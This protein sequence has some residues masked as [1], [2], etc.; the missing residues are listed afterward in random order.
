MQPVPDDQL[1]VVAPDD[2][3]FLPTGQSPLQNHEGFLHTTC[4][5]C[6]GPARRETDTM[7]TFVDSSWYFLRFCDPWAT[8]APFDREAAAG[9]MPVGQ[10][11]GGVE[12]AILHLMYAR[13]FTK[14]LADLGVAPPDL[15]EPFSRLFT[16][17]MVR[18][19]GT[20]MSK[21]KGNLVAPE[22]I[23]DREGADALRLAHLF[24]GPPADD[25]DWEGVGIDGCSRFLHRLWR[26]TTDGL[27]I[28]PVDRPESDIDRAV[29][30]STHRLIKKAS[31]DYERWSYNTVV[32]ACM[33]QLNDLYRYVQSDAGP[34]RETLATALDVLLL[35]LAPMA[36]HVTAELW[37]RRHGGEH[38]HEQRW[39]LA[40]PAKLEVE[41]VTMVVQVNGKVRAK[42]EVA[43]D[44][45]VDEA[46]ALALGTEKIAAMLDGR[47]PT[48][49]IA[50]PPKVVNVVV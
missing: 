45:S 10:Y 28:D 6:S 26:L 32:A 18:L 23:L 33:E 48:K 25:V 35:V 37:A 39:P 11:I 49:V 20:R 27:G 34:R 41:S 12:H 19:G 42:L 30:R 13:F 17:G 22:E 2:V 14:A 46:E 7:D 15:R 5:S 16:Q 40:D 4:P 8:D 24:V 47:S 29:D 50:R 21:S 31:D 38:V 44:I 36:P 9:W 3:E 1:P 43:P